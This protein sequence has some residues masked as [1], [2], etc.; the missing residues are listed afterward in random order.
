[1]RTKIGPSWRSILTPLPTR[2]PIVILLMD[3]MRLTKWD[4]S[5]IVAI[6]VSIVYWLCHRIL[7][8]FVNQQWDYGFFKRSSSFST[9]SVGKISRRKQPSNHPTQPCTISR[10]TVLLI[11]VVLPTQTISWFR[12]LWLTHTKTACWSSSE[13]IVYYIIMQWLSVKQSRSI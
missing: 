12:L 1:M 9:S 10:W 4:G 11:K 2:H 5:I 13:K 8:D 3:T 6:G 7:I